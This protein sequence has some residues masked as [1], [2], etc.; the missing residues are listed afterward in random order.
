MLR[1]VGEWSVS[2][3]T[4]AA[5]SDADDGS[6][7]AADP[8]RGAWLTFDGDG[9]VYGTGGVNRFRGTWSIDADRLVLGPMAST[10]VAGPPAAMRQEAE[11]LR[12]LGGPLELR[13]ADGTVQAAADPVRERVVGAAAPVVELVAPSGERLQLTRVVA[14]AR[15]R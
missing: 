4:R 13:S 9:Q 5:A 10:R 6:D 1:L 2:V 14:D 12:L 8:P 3:R 15:D 11:L 7:A